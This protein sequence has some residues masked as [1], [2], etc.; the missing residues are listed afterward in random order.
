MRF[1]VVANPMDA[2][3]LMVRRRDDFG[4]RRFGTKTIRRW[5]VRQQKKLPQNSISRPAGP[6]KCVKHK[7]QSAAD[8]CNK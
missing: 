5:T 8:G 3:R 4:N 6:I 7:I 1:F 2:M